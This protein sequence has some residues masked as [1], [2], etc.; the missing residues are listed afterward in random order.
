MYRFQSVVRQKAI[1]F[2]VNRAWIM[3]RAAVA[4]LLIFGALLLVGSLLPIVVH[5]PY[6]YSEPVRAH[7][8]ESRFA[9]GANWASLAR[10]APVFSYRYMH[11]GL[12]YQG[13]AYRPSGK[14][15]E[16]VR[17]YAPGLVI[18]VYVDPDHPGRAMIQPGM[19]MGDISRS[20]LGLVSMIF[21][22]ALL[23]RLQRRGI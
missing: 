3:R 14:Q 8:V 7:V 19:T 21:G 10:P 22:S 1:G 15:S 20:A 2:G 11:Q 16:A 4:A 13:S 23:V 18:D 9:E 5:W 17:R 6:N 12:L